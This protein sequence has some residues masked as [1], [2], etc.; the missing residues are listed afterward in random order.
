MV[1]SVAT[2][3]RKPMLTAICQVRVRLR[4]NASG[5]YLKNP[6]AVLQVIARHVISSHMVARIRKE[7]TRGIWNMRDLGYF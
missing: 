1:Y 3:M 5:S 7:A 4:G 2:D 6:F